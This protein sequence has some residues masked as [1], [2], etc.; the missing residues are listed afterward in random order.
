M[1][2]LISAVD[3]SGAVVARAPAA[4][5]P[6]GEA[7]AAA[8]GGF[9]C[10]DWILVTPRVSAE[11][12]ALCRV[13]LVPAHGAVAVAIKPA[14][15]AAATA[16]GASACGGETQPPCAVALVPAGDRVTVQI[17][18]A[19]DDAAAASS[20]RFA[21]APSAPGGGIREAPHTLAAARP[22]VVRLVPTGD[23]VAVSIRPR[24]AADPPRLCVVELTPAGDAVAVR[25]RPVGEAEGRAAAAGPCAVELVVMGGAVALRIRPCQAEEATATAAPAIEVQDVD[26]SVWGPLRAQLACSETE[27]GSVAPVTLVLTPLAVDASAEDACATAAKLLAAA[28]AVAAADAAAG[29]TQRRR[30]L[31]EVCV[32]CLRAA[33][34]VAAAAAADGLTPAAAAAAEGTERFWPAAAAIHSIAAA[35]V[36]H[37]EPPPP[38][39]PP[40]PT[41][42]P[43]AAAPGA[44]S[45]DVQVT[46]FTTSI[47]S[48][49]AVVAH[50]RRLQA[51]L[52]AF[53]VPYE[54][55]DLAAEPERRKDMLTGSNDN[56]AL[57]QLH[58]NGQSLGD[59]EDLLDAHDFGELLPMLKP[60]SA[61]AAP[62]PVAE[63]PEAA[64]VSEVAPPPQ[65]ECPELAAVLRDELCFLEGVFA[66]GTARAETRRVCESEGGSEERVC[67]L[68]GLRG[69]RWRCEEVTDGDD[70]LGWQ[71]VPVANVWRRF[72]CPQP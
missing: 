21:T 57:P 67:R 1:R 51:I 50:S 55:V 12:A 70:P 8:S 30:Q 29:P 11:A 17:R 37:R 56:R 3:S 34:A 39:P 59:A 31:A 49:R 19:A 63:E 58:V 6:N 38:P 62:P 48:A 60:A 26:R 16:P 24:G 35:L 68:S 66:H 40:P 5:A 41:P 43:A 27:A 23:S 4:A 45:G 25:I 72:C 7:A 65:L 44:A 47:S 9:D 54:A 32:R 33:D 52:E 36:R 2:V 61:T 14:G 28:P 22:C 15:V 42:P 53:A 69:E 46:F 64:E 71:I 20:D 13:E 10:E 18:A